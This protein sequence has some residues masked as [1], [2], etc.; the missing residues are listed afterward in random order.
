MKQVMKHPM[1]RAMK[2]A[3]NWAMKTPKRRVIV[4]C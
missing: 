4:I 2:V 1:K 3:I